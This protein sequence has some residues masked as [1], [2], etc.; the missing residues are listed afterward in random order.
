[1]KRLQTG[2]DVRGESE[3]RIT[4]NRGRNSD[5]VFASSRRS[6]PVMPAGFFFLA[7]GPK[8]TRSY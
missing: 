1:M 5:R 8:D 7:H 2:Q 3:G 6:P 4:L